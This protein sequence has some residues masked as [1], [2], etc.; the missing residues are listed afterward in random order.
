MSH[1]KE[2]LVHILDHMNIQVDNP[3]SLLDQDT[4]RHFLHSNNPAHKY[5]VNGQDKGVC[6][7]KMVSHSSSTLQL[8]IKATRLEQIQRDYDRAE[9]DQKLMQ[10]SIERNEAV[11]I[12]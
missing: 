10:R 5:K 4:S 11:S 2:E 12:P 3:V 6:A 8:F 7:S 1:K 9:E